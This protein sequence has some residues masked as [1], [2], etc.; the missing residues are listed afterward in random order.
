MVIGL[1]VKPISYT[2]STSNARRRLL[3]H[4]VFNSPPLLL[5]QSLIRPCTRHST[6]HG[7]S[8]HFYYHDHHHSSSR[9]LPLSM[10]ELSTQAAADTGLRTPFVV[11]C[12]VPLTPAPPPEMPLAVAYAKSGSSS[13]N[14][15]LSSHSEQKLVI[16]AANRSDFIS[17]LIGILKR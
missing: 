14:N 3:P 17:G 4:F 11:V 5:L 12:G 7:I 9:R 16:C 8:L 13:S 10:N 1:K 6:S 2:T 15:T